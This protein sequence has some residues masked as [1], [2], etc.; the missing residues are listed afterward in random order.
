MLKK[1]KVIENQLAGLGEWGG[2]VKVLIETHCSIG[3]RKMPRST[4]NPLAL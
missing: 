4:E 1:E 2:C 3:L